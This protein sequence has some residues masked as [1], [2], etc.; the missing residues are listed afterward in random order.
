MAHCF[1]IAHD[2]LL[3]YDAQSVRFDSFIMRFTSDTGWIRL[4]NLLQSRCVHFE[5]W[6]LIFE[7]L[8]SYSY[9]M[10]LMYNTTLAVHYKVRPCYHGLCCIDFCPY[11]VPKASTS[12]MV[13][14]FEGVF[15]LCT[16]FS[17]SFAGFYLFIW[18]IKKMQRL[19]LGICW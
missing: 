5:R 12:L 3:I 7:L 19:K 6:Y 13:E 4:L 16:V 17:I 9:V 18:G 1:H 2:D 11:I 8:Y 10:D 15:V 14:R